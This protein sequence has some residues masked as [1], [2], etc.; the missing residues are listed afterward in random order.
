MTGQLSFFEVGVADVTKARTFYGELFGWRF[1]ATARGG[2]TIE[3][4]PVSDGS[5][6]VPGGIHGG[7][8]GAAPYL[9]FAV[10]DIEQAVA[11]VRELGGSVIDTD[12]EGDTD[13]QAT[14]GRF[15]L[16]RDDQGSPFGLHQ[17]P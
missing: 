4:D 6:R 9:F 8:A 12:L 5:R 2:S 11:K 7:D 1:A 14:F 17:R 16:C 10:D 13:D 15:R 3:T